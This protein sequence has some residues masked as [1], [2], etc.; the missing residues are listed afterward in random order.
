MADQSLC[1]ICGVRP[2]G[3]R[4]HL[5]GVAAAND[6]PVL[7]TYPVSSQGSPGTLRHEQREEKDGFVVR[8]ICNHCNSRTGGSLGT[9]YKRFVLGF[10]ASGILDAGQLR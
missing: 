6:H 7:V 9:A 2:A 3:S 10:A 4:E 1:N 8:T 5:P